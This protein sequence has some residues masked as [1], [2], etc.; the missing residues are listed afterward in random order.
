MLQW[1]VSQDI[2]IIGAGI[3]GL[4]AAAE[5]LRHG[6]RT[7]ILEATD[8]V[9][10]RVHTVYDEGVPIELGAEF[11]HG[12]SN[13]IIQ[14]L[15]DAAL[16]THEV[17][18]EERAFSNGKC[19]RTAS[20]DQMGELIHRID[21]MKPDVSF[22]DFLANQ[23]MRPHFRQRALSFVEGFNAARAERISAHALLRSQISAERME[24]PSQSRINEGYGALLRHFVNEIRARGG[25]IQTNAPVQWVGWKEGRVSVRTRASSTAASYGAAIVTVS[26]GV[27]KAGIIAFDPPL[28][29]K[30]DAIEGLE[31]GH[32][33][34]VSLHFKEHWWGEPN[35]GFIH[36]LDEPLP[37]WWS[38]P[39][40]ATLTGWA[41][42]PKAEALKSWTTQDLE[43]A[44]LEI[45][46]RI[47]S[48]RP[49]VLGNRLI[50]THTHNW[51]QDP[52]VRGAYSY[53][54][55][56]GLDLPKL[57]AAP[58]DH[59]LFFAGEATMDDAQSGLV[60]GALESG[61]RAAHELLDGSP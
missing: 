23:R 28:I 52:W 47:F 6:R 13:S 39:R 38:D 34:R 20:F 24:N 25:C 26:L 2:V 27:L 46:G 32:A 5:L 29:R 51:A 57:L 60:S 59:T 4:A 8:R 42:G 45:L 9:G 48:E 49:S 10:G 31:F 21:P 58:I 43:K 12:Q 41:G 3:S 7:T 30:Q 35:F 16:T 17:A 33:R 55:V 56:N 44:G 22:A 40:G 18:Q 14:V 19:R 61:L 11:L 53:I 50:T 15:R 36:S 1:G 37:T 54:P